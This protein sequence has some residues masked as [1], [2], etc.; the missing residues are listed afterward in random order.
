M[1]PAQNRT[2]AGGE[3]TKTERFRDIIVGSKLQS[4]DF[5][6]FFRFGRNHDDPAGGVLSQ[7]TA[8]VDSAFAWQHPVEQDNGRFRCLSE[9]NRFKSVHRGKD[10]EAFLFQILRHGYQHLLFV[11]H[12]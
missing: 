5:I 10:M 9:A 3:L 1:N 2:N 6:G 4:D 8:H 7:F 12:D 11:F